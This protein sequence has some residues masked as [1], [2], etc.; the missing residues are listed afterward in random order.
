MQKQFISLLLLAVLW[1]ANPL[2]AQELKP[3]YNREELIEVMHVSAR[4]GGVSAY[5]AGIAEPE[6][7]K[8]AY[9]SPVMGLQNMWSL[10]VYDKTA[11]I[12]IRGTVNE[13]ESWLA[14]LYAAMVPAKGQIILSDKDTFNYQL[15][16][17]P[18]AA[19][20]AGWLVATGFIAKDLMPRLDS[21]YKTGIKDFIITGHSQ[22]GGIAYLLTAYL[23]NKQ[24]LD[25]LPKDI[26]FKTYCS[27]AP[28][29]G[30]LYFAYEYEAATQ[31]GWAFNVVNAADWVP[32][33]PF[34]IQTIHDFNTVNPF[35][36]IKY[37]IK[38][39]PLIKRIAYKTLYNRLTG[40][41][42]KA[43]ECFEKY[44][45]EKVSK[46][47]AKS[48]K[49]FEAPQYYSSNNYVRTG[50]TIVLTPDEDYYKQFNNKDGAN[51]FV[52]HF[53]QPYIYLIERL[54]L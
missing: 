48:L 4:T 35:D 20:H 11:V 38:K 12:T 51:V 1:T 49:G 46:E 7:Y 33:V 21:C 6:H 34:S 54:K 23:L 22:G 19:V 25:G 52:N 28:K 2:S 31:G 41:P 43:Q 40:P 45:G 42:E 27:A 24:K 18:R 39:Q 26:R 3:G 37:M 32:E 15:A 17:D 13:S 53:H 9:R 44:L 36:S 10:W 29:P 16:E 5:N 47:V 14:N 8:L 50:N 30:N